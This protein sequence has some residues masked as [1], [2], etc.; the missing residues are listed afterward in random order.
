[1]AAPM[2]F[3]SR[4]TQG[5]M[6]GLADP[7]TTQEELLRRRIVAPN[8]TSE[9]GRKHGFDRIHTVAEYQR[10]VPIA[11]YE[12]FAPMIDRIVHGR[13]QGI[14]TSEPV[15]RFFMTSGSMAGAKYIPVT[16]SFVRDKSRAFGVYWNTVFEQHQAARSGRMVTNFSDSGAATSTPGRLPCSSESAFWAGVTRATQLATEPIIPEAVARIE[17]PDARYYAIARILLEEPFSVI[18]TLNPST[19]VRLF[20]TLVT[21][22]DRLIADVRRGGLDGA[23]PVG[24]DVRAH[25]ARRYS[26]NAARATELSALAKR[27][28]LK[29][30]EV[31]S[32]LALGICWRSPMLAPYLEL[33]TPHFGPVVQRDYL[34]MASEGVMAIPIVDGRS[35]GPVAVGVHFYEFVP[36]AQ[37]DR[38]DPDVLL[39]HELRTGE[40]YVIVLT[41]GSGLYRYDI[42]DVVRVTGF[43]H[44]TPCIEFLHRS[45][46]TCSLTGEK[47]TEDQVTAAVAEAGRSLGIDV[48]AFTLAPADGGFPH[49]VAFVELERPATKERLCVFASHLD[50]ALARQNLEYGSKRT[51]GRLDAPE[52]RLVATGSYEAL[53]R[54]RLIRGTS[55]SQIKPTHLTRDASFG[56]AFEILA[57]Y[58]ARPGAVDE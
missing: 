58:S 52:L 55:D 33:L 18:M 8:I 26:G 39:P 34:L 20:S 53:R 57:R 10:A 54:S 56:R 37:V 50:R 29:A 17:D 28:E 40:R 44:R 2:Q 27:G 41:N 6:A 42:G 35:G 5:F 25:V 14:L 32:E 49:Y 22:G 16:S 45:G 43:V 38:S 9:F 19:I 12:D 4:E 11:R 13:E 23:I 1:M 31:W 51:S 30:H 7:K 47:L 46:A 24:D 48:G 21:A 36:E 3:R 15:R